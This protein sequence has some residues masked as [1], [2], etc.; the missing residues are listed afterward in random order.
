MMIQLKNHA[1]GLALLQV[2]F[3]FAWITNLSPLS[4]T[5]TYYSVYLLCAIIGI[6]CLYDN[7][8]KSAECA[9]Y[10]SIVLMLFSALFSLAVLLANYTLFEPLTVLQN[11]LDAV[12]CFAGGLSIAWN[13]LLCLM[14]RLPLRADLSERKHPRALFFAVFCS[15]AVIDLLY[16]L[17]VLY[18]GV[19][20]R[21]S[22]TTIKQIM[23]DDAYD[24]VMPFWHTMT[25][26]LFVEIGL[27]LFG[28]M[29]AAVAFFHGAQIL[30]IAACFAYALM[31]LYQIGIPRLWLVVVYAVYVFMPYNIVYSVTL[32][33]DVV[34]AG[35]ALLFVTS[36]YRILREIGKS[37]TWNYVLITIG[38]LGFSLWRTNGWYA[39]LLTTLVLLILLRRHYKKL[40]II[41]TAVLILC[42]V[43]L[44]PFLDVIGIK[45]TNFVEAF[46]VPMQQ[47]ARVISNERELTEEETALLSEIFWLDEVKDAY[48][49]KTVDPIKFETFRY[50][51]VDY[52]TEH[53]GEYL[54]LYLR[55]GLRYP[56]DYLKAWIEETKGYWNGGYYYWVYTK[57]VDD[58]AYGIAY[59]PQDNVVSKLYGAV[60]R[61]L[62][63]PEIMQS[64][65]SIGLHVWAI[66]ACCLVN[67]LKKRKEFLLTIP[68][69]TLIVGLWL[70]TPVY[71]EFR[72][73]YPMI[74]AAPVIVAS[75]FFHAQEK[76]T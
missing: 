53:L 75:T 52:I 61:Y 15:V 43:L 8:Q 16:L 68:L 28:N 24:N 32:W 67:V 70:G 26:K 23:G 63:K 73:A 6:L 54:K 66:V 41:M 50:D 71:A 60:F 58:N 13:I 72:Y 55:L 3:V 46:A 2:G 22:V 7:Y 42:W 9:K 5:D 37:Q 30:F 69:L 31:T 1:K 74:L 65:S 10:H 35:A 45:K 59:T 20:T 36:F 39:F 25:V 29:N 47:I 76:L 40:L 44:N 12:L 18:P 48:D 21:D 14:N 11:L 62:E 56:G 19:L 17:L 51:K 4:V 38:A 49:P 34:F 27:G 33:K 64:F 57:G